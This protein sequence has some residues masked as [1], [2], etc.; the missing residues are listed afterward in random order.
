MDEK[1]I[2]LIVICIA[3]TVTNVLAIMANPSGAVR[4]AQMIMFEENIKYII[5]CSKRI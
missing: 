2:A 4:K 3:V 1:G 5:S